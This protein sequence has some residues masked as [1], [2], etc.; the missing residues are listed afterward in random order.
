MAHKSAFSYILYLLN[1]KVNG[2]VLELSEWSFKANLRDNIV[3]LHFPSNLTL[4]DLGI[5]EVQKSVTLV[6]STDSCVY[7]MFLEHPVYHVRSY[8]NQLLVMCSQ[9][10]ILPPYFD[11][12]AMHRLCCIIKQIWSQDNGLIVWAPDHISEKN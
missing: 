10:V 3:R 4:K 2:C 5:F 12:V 1:R 9:T 8:G 7:C 11:D 6:C